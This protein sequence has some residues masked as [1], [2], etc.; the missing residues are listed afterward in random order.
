MYEST[1]S[2]ATSKLN[3]VEAELTATRGDLD[4]TVH[5]AKAAEEEIE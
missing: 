3:K 4:R 1:F 5:M 2:Q